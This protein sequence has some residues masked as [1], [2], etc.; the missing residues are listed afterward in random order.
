MSWHSHP[1]LC[2][3]CRTHAMIRL[4]CSP[5]CLPS[6]SVP[7]SRRRRGSSTGNEDSNKHDNRR[8][9]YERVKISQKAPRSIRYF[10]PLPNSKVHTNGVEVQVRQSDGKQFRR[11]TCMYIRPPRPLLYRRLPS[12][13]CVFQYQWVNSATRRHTINSLTSLATA[14]AR[15]PDMKA[16]RHRRDGPTRMF[17]DSAKVT[18]ASNCAKVGVSTGWR[19]GEG[20]R[21]D[22]AQ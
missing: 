11:Y 12:I 8:C 21:H 17:V 7:S 10:L 16:G 18:R 15:A 14:I 2:A 9:G 1:L 5:C 22:T 20:R 13:M 4:V 3:Y 6:L 19:G